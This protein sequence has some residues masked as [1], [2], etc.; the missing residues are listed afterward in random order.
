MKKSVIFI[1]ILSVLL[2]LSLIVLLMFIGCSKNSN[3]LDNPVIADTSENLGSLDSSDDIN[4]IDNINMI[5][6]ES[7]EIET[8]E[9]EVPVQVTAELLMDDNFH[10]YYNFEP[11]KFLDR[12]IIS[13]DDKLRKSFDKQ[14]ANINRII[15]SDMTVNFYV[16]VFTRMQDTEYAKELVPDEFSTLD[17]FNEFV[18]DSITGAKDIGWFDI[19]TIEKRVE[20]VF[21]TDHHWSALGSYS[22]YVDVINMM[23]KYTP[24]IGEPLPLNGETGLITFPDVQMRGSF[25]ATM[26]FDDY[27]ETFSVL[28]ITLPKFTRPEMH[29]VAY[30][31]YIAGKFNKGKFADH[32][33]AYYNASSQRR[34]KVPSNSTGRNLLMISDSYSWWFAWIVAANFDNVYLYLPPWDAKK[35]DYNKYIADNRITDVLLAQFSDRLFFNYYSDSNLAMIRTA[36]GENN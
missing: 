30:D 15:A 10:R 28:D 1:C 27:Y 5:E 24:E 34:Y 31:Q 32:Y 11:Y 14:V 19:D 6:S 35:F 21:R 29:T 20:R 36:S 16:Y 9:A 17:F 26:G 22:G 3:Q 8:E 7:V 18:N 13:T 4:T 23:K 25:A 33:S 2:I 12:W